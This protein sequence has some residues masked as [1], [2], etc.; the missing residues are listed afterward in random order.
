MSY[1]IKG[2]LDKPDLNALLLLLTRTKKI[3]M[4]SV[5]VWNSIAEILE[6][7]EEYF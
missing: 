5:D 3:K 2:T 1:M 7:N 6:N 4:Y